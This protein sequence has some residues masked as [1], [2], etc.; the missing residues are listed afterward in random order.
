MF[1][2]QVS[3]LNN[4]NSDKT[5]IQI[6]KELHRKVKEH[7]LKNN[8]KVKDFLEEIILKNL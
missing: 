2:I 4:H 5:Y 7:C 8:L 1:E 3:F 6:S